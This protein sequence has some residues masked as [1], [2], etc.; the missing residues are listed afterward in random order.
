MLELVHMNES[1]I[2]EI[3]SW[4]TDEAEVMQ[5]A[6]PAYRINSLKEDMKSSYNYFKENPDKIILL[7][8][9]KRGVDQTIGHVQLFIDNLNES[10]GIGRMIVNPSLRQNGYGKE[11]ISKILEIGFINLK[12]NLIHLA[13]FDFNLPAIKCYQ[14]FGFVEEGILRDRRKVGDKFWSLISMSISK[15]EYQQLN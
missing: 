5:W 15:E 10:V 9:V 1:D 14:R 2:D 4:V 7:K 11:I 13:V 6:G 8:A 3:A 12:K